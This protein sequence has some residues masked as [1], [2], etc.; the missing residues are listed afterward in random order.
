[1]AEYTVDI[2]DEG[3]LA[4]EVD[5]VDDVESYIEDFKSKKKS[6]TAMTMYEKARILGVRAKQIQDGVG[7][8]PQVKII[9]GWYAGE[10]AKNELEL[11]KI[12]L[13]I[14]RVFADGSFEI[15]KVKHMIIP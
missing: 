3:E 12:P 14:K 15:W 2:L 8:P 5:T 10:I 13:S 4:L 7:K 9:R 1:M 11:M 6:S